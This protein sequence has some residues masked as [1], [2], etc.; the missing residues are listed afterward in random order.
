MAKIVLKNAYL[1]IAA[2]TLSGDVK[3]VGI[4]Y[5]AQALDNT[6]MGENTKTSQGGLFDWPVTLE[7]FQDWTAAALD[8]ILFPL[9]GTVVAIEIRPDAGAR[10]TSNPAYTG[11]ALLE[12]YEPISGSVGQMAMTKISLKPAGDLSRLT[13]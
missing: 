2:N 13:A 5:S 9:V 8:S 7:L 1:S 4:T 12:S 3:Q 11:N 10:S 6:S